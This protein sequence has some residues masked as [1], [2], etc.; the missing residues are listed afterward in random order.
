MLGATDAGVGVLALFGVAALLRLRPAANRSRAL[1]ALP[2]LWVIGLPLS[3]L[4]RGVPVLSRYLLILAPI[5]AW[6][7]WRTLDDWEARSGGPRRVM[8]VL[9]AS[10]IVIQNLVVYRAVVVPQ[11]ESFTR[12]LEGELIPWARWFGEHSPSGAA[13]ATPDIGV[14][15]Y[16]SRRPILDLAGLITPG[17]VRYLGSETQEEV[18]ARFRFAAIARPAFLVD[19][20]GGEYRLLEDSPYAASLVPLGLARVPNLGV[21]R[22]EPATYSFY[23]IDWNT[24]DSLRVAQPR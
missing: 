18:I 22:P 16:F 4:L 23:R 2:W 14:F 9:V 12:A 8:A 5:L 20:G 3:Y 6:L 17:M 21:A 15:G 7:G 24:F 19:R 1:E 11:V 10:L 13:I